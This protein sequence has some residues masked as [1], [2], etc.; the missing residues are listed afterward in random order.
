MLSTYSHHLSAAFAA[1]KL[2]FLDLADPIR[3]DDRLY[4]E[5]ETAVMIDTFNS[6]Q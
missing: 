1:E 2:A 5:P 3:E 6:I 4:Q